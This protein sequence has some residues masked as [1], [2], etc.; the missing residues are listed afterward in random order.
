MYMNKNQKIIGGIVAVVVAVGLFYGGVKYGEARG[1]RPGM[2]QAQFNR[3]GGAQAFRSGGQNGG[4]RN[5]MRG[6][7]VFG[8][9]LSK[10]DKSITIESMSGGSRIVLT[11]ESMKV[12]KSVAGTLEDVQV[13]ATVSVEG[14]ANPDGS[15]TAQTVQV[16]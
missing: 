16:R 3:Q 5:M 1:I 7:I 4:Q 8:K 12:L 10:D 6:N 15:L 2:G 9:I 13:G 11:A 14:T